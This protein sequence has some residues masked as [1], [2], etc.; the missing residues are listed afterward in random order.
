MVLRNFIKK[1]IDFGLGFFSLDDYNIDKEMDI[2]SKGLQTL[3]NFN[4]L[5][6]FLL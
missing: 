1:K 6:I 3:L 2:F 4:N 5:D